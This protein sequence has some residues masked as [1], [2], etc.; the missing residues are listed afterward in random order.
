MQ[1][2]IFYGDCLQAADFGFYWSTIFCFYPM[3]NAE[4]SNDTGPSMDQF[5]SRSKELFRKEVYDVCAF[6]LNY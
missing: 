5:E 6:P 1:E 3:V 2:D 4:T